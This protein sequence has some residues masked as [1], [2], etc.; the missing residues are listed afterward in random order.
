MS[1]KLMIFR[2]N[3]KNGGIL[4]FGRKSSCLKRIRAYHKGKEGGE[5]RHFLAQKR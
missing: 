4:P 1:N 2:R 3:R 5:F